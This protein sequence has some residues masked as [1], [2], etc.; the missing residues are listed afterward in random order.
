MPDFI[1]DDTNAAAPEANDGPKG[2]VPRDFTVQPRKLEAVAFPLIPRVEWPERIREAEAKKSRLSDIRMR[3]NFGKPIP[4]LDQNSGRNDQR[5]GY[6]WNHS[7]THA[8]MLLRAKANLPYVALSAFAGA[9][10]IK[11]GRNDGGWGAQGLQ[12][13]I[14]HGYPSQAFWPQNNVDLRNG[15]PECWADAARHKVVED[16]L[17]LN[18]P[19]YAQ[20]LTF[21]QVGTLLLSNI[22]VI[23]DFNW[24]GHS[25][26]IMDLVN[27]GTQGLRAESGKLADLD[28]QLKAFELT[29]GFDDRI[30]NSWSDS[31]GELGTAVLR[32]TRA[33]P[34]Q[35]AAPL[36]LSA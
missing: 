25:V 22:P 18:T 19:I 5:W 16:W 30:W 6:C 29:D 20:R 23:G 14:E 26:C 31:F 17:D 35:A 32:G 1:I 34:D 10:T 2:C 13:G 12:F 28:E 21:D 33:I 8:A 3:G 27:G 9:A 11:Q 36:T 15:T 24:W 4:S 7:G